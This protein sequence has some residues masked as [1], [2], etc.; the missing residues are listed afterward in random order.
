MALGRQLERQLNIFID[1]TVP[2]NRDYVNNRQLDRFHEQDKSAIPTNTL[3]EWS[4]VYVWSE[5]FTQSVQERIAQSLH[6]SFIA[7]FFCAASRSG[8]WWN[9][10]R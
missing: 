3:C 1:H 7:T 9:G 2:T 10:R 6:F 8:E 5:H 4:K